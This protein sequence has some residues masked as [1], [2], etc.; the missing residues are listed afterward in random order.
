MPELPEVE[1]SRQGITPFMLG[2]TVMRIV[3]RNPSLRWPVPSELQEMVGLTI[4]AVRRRAKYL[5][6]ET[7]WGTAILHLGMSGNLRILDHGTPPGKHDHVDIELGN[8]KLLRFNDTRRFG[9]LLWTRESA[10]QHALLVKLGPE[11]LTAD[12]HDDYLYERSRKRKVA[13]KQFIMDNHVVVGV[14]NIYANESLFSAGINPEQPAN[15]V[16][17]LQYA[18]LTTEI[19]L[20]LARAIKQG[21]TTLKD[22]TGSD[23]KPGYFVQELQVYGRAE[24]PCS[25][26]GGLL[27]EVRMGGRSTVFCPRCQPILKS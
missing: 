4:I 22:F 7:D 14:G 24:Q 27:K 10:E 8:G 13:V 19:K 5:L 25:A 16:T 17:P 1:V 21:G 26:C 3:V 2:E 15:E 18:S 9:C 12:F 11:P 6:L 20:V 23:G